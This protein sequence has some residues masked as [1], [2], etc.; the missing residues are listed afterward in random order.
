M[1]KCVKG[2]IIP[3][4]ELKNYPDG[5]EFWIEDILGDDPEENIRGFATKKYDDIIEDET[6]FYDLE[7]LEIHPEMADHLK[8]FSIEKYYEEFDISE[9]TEE[10]SV[11]EIIKELAEEICNLRGVELTEKN[12]LDVVA[13][14]KCLQEKE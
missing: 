12:I 10:E 11:Q 2:D 5:T 14:L 7:Y 8:Y 9:I 13:S 4:N 3:F 6:G 1:K